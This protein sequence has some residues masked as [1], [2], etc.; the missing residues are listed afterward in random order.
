[1][2]IDRDT[3][4]CGLRPSA[5][6]AVL[7]KSHFSTIDAMK[8]WAMNEPK[9]SQTLR[10]LAADDW[11]A[12]ESVRGHIDYWDTTDKGRRMAVSR[13]IKR[14]P[15]ADGRTILPRVVN[16]AR[17]L[18]RDPTSSR[19][20]ESIALF[21][22]VLTG[23]EHGDAGDID[24]VVAVRRRNLPKS[25]IEALEAEED[26]RAPESQSW[27][28][29]SKQRE[30]E[31]LRAI[32]KV[33][34]R[35]SIHA[36]S[37]LDVLKP[38]HRVLYRFDL[39]QEREGQVSGETVPAGKRVV[40]GRS[41]RD[42]QQPKLPV[43]EIAAWPR[44]QNAAA[45]AE[46]V[47]LE[48]LLYCQHYWIRGEGLE[49]ISQR[50][51]VSADV[52]QA[53][54]SSLTGLPPSHSSELFPSLHATAVGCGLPHAGHVSVTRHPG[55]SPSVDAVMFEQETYDRLARA[56]RSARYAGSFRGQAHYFPI[57]DTVSF[58][59]WQWANKLALAAPQLG[60]EC[61]A[62]R[63]GD[64]YTSGREGSFPHLAEFVE[65]MMEVL[66]EQ[67]RGLGEEWNDFQDIVSLDFGAG[68]PLQ[69]RRRGYG[70]PYRGTRILKR[71]AP[72]VWNLMLNFK[73]AYPFLASP[74]ERFSIYVR[75]GDD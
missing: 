49:T 67:K 13:L 19:R 28:P 18:N 11:I 59:V 60:F 72:K 73:A 30:R 17:E 23:D 32:K 45:E 2:Q 46:R 26:K 5:L 8:A 69:R 66:R 16:K 53:Y 52:C 20:I 33:S 29:W 48:A 43:S 12:Y 27:V 47:E 56:Y 36:E 68:T 35:I 54:L 1:V 57:L 62:S 4:I 34:H 40:E 58:T 75:A 39:N 64:N 25:E 61:S 38:T 10:A 9:A 42:R 70:W 74:G 22:S 41:R 44:A 6:K 71:D 14:F 65:P 37:D 31:L 55:F 51:R 24:L 15:I 21:G 7:R 63:W 50:T 3:P